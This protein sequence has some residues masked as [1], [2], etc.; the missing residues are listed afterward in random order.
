[1][2]T[3]LLCPICTSDLVQPILRD[4]E[5]LARVQEGWLLHDLIGVTAFSCEE[6][7]VFFVMSQHGD[8]EDAECEVEL[9]M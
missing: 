4:V 1:M 2:A 7:H 5:F 6:G 3:K 8:V 9:V